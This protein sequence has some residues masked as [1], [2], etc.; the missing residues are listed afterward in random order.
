MAA[1]Y[2]VTQ[3]THPTREAAERRRESAEDTYYLHAGEKTFD[4]CAPLHGLK[5]L[6]KVGTVALSCQATPGRG[7][8]TLCETEI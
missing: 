4:R 1:T 2:G 6:K 3:V 5:P 8:G 7:E